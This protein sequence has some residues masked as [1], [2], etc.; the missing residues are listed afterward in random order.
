MSIELADKALN[1]IKVELMEDPNTLFYT[2]VFFSLNHLW[3]TS[4]ETAC[5]NGYW[6]KFNPDFFLAQS[7]KQQLG[8]VLH[9][10]EH[11]AFMHMARMNERNPEKWNIACDHVINLG[12]TERG[13]QLPDKG[14]CDKAYKGMSAEEVYAL[15]PDPPKSFTMDLVMA[16]G[17]GSDDSSKEG[18]QSNVTALEEHINDILIRAAMQV[19]ASGADAGQIPA[20]IQV[21]LDKLLN[22]RLPWNRLLSRY[23]HA[24][25][26]TDYSFRK[27]NRRYFPD[28][29]L[30]SQHG[31]GL[32]N[33]AIALDMSGSVSDKQSSHF[34]S[35]MRQIVK[36]LGPK[37]LELAQFDT[38][39]KSVHKVT[40][41]KDLE[42]VTYHGRGGTRIDP[43]MHWLKGTQH[44]VAIIFTDGYFQSPTVK[45]KMPVIWVIHDN[46]GFQ[47]PFGR[48]IHYDIP[49]N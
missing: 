7:S 24:L 21:R 5:T 16:E 25:K 30:P 6:I 28:M 39:I 13:F 12:L 36:Q 40:S 47:A 3:D 11:V 2:N 14:F 34:A 42:K 10:T 15:L 46:P 8:L 37:L 31:E 17:D 49:D 48:V 20:H 26:K 29:L 4:I 33:I 1:K 23:C 44:D 45:P 27:P 32:G 22:P 43:V 18:A 38:D 35:E 41:L 19:K 9:E